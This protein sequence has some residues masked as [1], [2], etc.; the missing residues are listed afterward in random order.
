LQNVLAASLSATAQSERRFKSLEQA[1]AR[2]NA[3]HVN[4]NTR[5]ASLENK[6]ATDTT[7]ASMLNPT[8]STAIKPMSCVCARA[9][10]GGSIDTG[11]QHHNFK[12]VVGE[13]SQ[14][15]A[16]S[17]LFGGTGGE[18]MMEIGVPK[19]P[20]GGKKDGELHA[21]KVGRCSLRTE[22]VVIDQQSKYND[23]QTTDQLIKVKAE[24]SI[25]KKSMV[26]H[27]QNNKM[28]TTAMTK[29]ASESQAATGTISLLQ[30]TVNQHAKQIRKFRADLAM[31]EQTE[32]KV[33]K[34]N[35]GGEVNDTT[36]QDLSN[37]RK[38]EIRVQA[39]ASVG[40]L[41][42]PTRMIGYEPGVRSWFPL[43]SHLPPPLS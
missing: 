39:Q 8:V 32:D 33:P 27:R 38:S 30:L 41:Q 1:I 18:L 34:E 42:L 11:G 43:F 2:L 6:V 25:I 23:P 22:P 3:G 4:H 17:T 29:L 16:D 24:L 10:D 13:P 36:S 15:E 5:M 9:V 31:F 35:E 7:V 40:L 28:V 37:E 19:Y 26:V 20:V 12:S 21:S 14:S